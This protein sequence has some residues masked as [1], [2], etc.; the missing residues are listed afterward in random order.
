L[1]VIA[2]I[3]LLVGLLLP[4]IQKVRVAADRTTCRNNLKQLG[5]ATHSY[6]NANR[7]WLPP[8]H[9]IASEKPGATVAQASDPRSVYGSWFL[10]LLP[11]VEQEALYK[12]L[13]DS[14]KATGHN[15]NVTVGAT[16]ATTPAGAGTVW[17]PESGCVTVP[18]SGCRTVTTTTQIEVFNNGHSQWNVTSQTSKVC[19]VYGSKVCDVYG[20][21]EGPNPPRSVLVTPGSTTTYGI[22]MSNVKPTTFKILRCPGDIST[23][24]SRLTSDGWGATSYLAN[25]WAFGGRQGKDA[26]VDGGLLSGIKDGTSATLLYAEAYGICDETNR[27]ALYAADHYFGFTQE[28]RIMENGAL[29]LYTPGWANTM[30]FQVMPEPLAHAKCPAGQDCCN[31]WTVQGMHPDVIQVV[32][33]DGSVR[34]LRQGMSPATWAALRKP[35]DGQNVNSLE[36]E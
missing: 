23:P 18:E 7:G 24:K 13:D 3:A 2:I 19:D 11:H 6:V 17:V 25:W 16:Y 27:R 36:L 21:W 34:S 5:V 4:A 12:L 30:M 10:H 35:N 9:G 31:N 14:A 26:F 22:W 33:F 15:E 20:H 29:K 8:Y 1:V 32:M 28:V